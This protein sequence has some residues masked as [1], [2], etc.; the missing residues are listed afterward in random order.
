M[1]FKKFLP[2]QSSSVYVFLDPDTQYHYSAGTYP[3][4]VQKIIAYRSQNKLDPIENLSF[5][6]DNYLCTL[7]ENIGKCG[8]ATLRRNFLGFIKG[9]ISLLRNMAYD[10]YVTQSRA[11]ERSAICAAC[12]HNVKPEKGAFT[13]WADRVAEASIGSR[14][15][16]HHD[17]LGTCDCCGC[18]LR[19]KVFIGEKIE[20]TEEE[21]EEMSTNENCWQVK[22][23]GRK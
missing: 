11:D 21:V 7:P 23:Y 2:F 14:R 3:E 9:G 16:K 17:E 1:I 15:S 8:P 22:E 13:F 12:P 6:L 10:A 20:L 18:P 5:V 19:P 4:L